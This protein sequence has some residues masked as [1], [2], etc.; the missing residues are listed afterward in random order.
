MLTEVWTGAEILIRKSTHITVT[1]FN[2]WIN[3]IF[4]YFFLN[5]THELMEKVRRH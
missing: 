4:A 2:Q 3:M 5:Q 1:H